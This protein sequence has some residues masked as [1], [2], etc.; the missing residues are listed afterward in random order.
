MQ[1]NQAKQL[2]CDNGGNSDRARYW[3]M[4]EQSVAGVGVL[5]VDAGRNGGTTVKG[6]SRNEVLVRARAEGWGNMMAT[7]TGSR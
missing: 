5:D 4:R 6:W 2:T 7:A 3:E 1:D